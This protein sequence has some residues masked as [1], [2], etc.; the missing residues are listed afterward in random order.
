MF[1]MFLTICMY[2]HSQVSDPFFI[3]FAYLF[4]GSFVK[5][6]QEVYSYG[7]SF[8][9]SIYELR[10]WMMK[11]GV[12]YFYATLNAILDR[13]GMMEANF[14]LTNKD[15]EEDQIKRHQ[16]GIYDFQAAPMLLVPLCSLYLINVTS[17]I[18]GAVK[19][20]KNHTGDEMFAQAI[21]SFFGIVLNYYLLEG[22][23]LRTDKGRVSPF[24]SVIS[25]AITAVF[26]LVGPFI[27]LY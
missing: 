11:S 26:L 21:L 19:I 9:T 4:I 18:L 22:M 20:V 6:V 5:H 3:V 23:I 16:D 10:V 27:M 7:D 17:F 24:V 2:T 25:V 13:L 12:C 8:R 14:S 1:G 15:I